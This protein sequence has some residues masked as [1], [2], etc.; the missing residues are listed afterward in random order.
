MS[1]KWVNADDVA[2]GETVI[3]QI[4]KRI[5]DRETGI[6]WA[7]KLM[8]LLTFALDSHFGFFFSI[9]FQSDELNAGKE[10]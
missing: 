8:C 4:S 10:N 5:G 9:H 3:Y 6:N 1:M 2:Y 7:I